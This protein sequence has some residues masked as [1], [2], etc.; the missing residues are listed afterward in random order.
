MFSLAVPGCCDFW[1]K[2]WR[3]LC[4]CA[5]FFSFS[6]FYW[7]FTYILHIICIT[8]LVLSHKTRRVTHIS[9]IRLTNCNCLPFNILVDS[10]IWFFEKKWRELCNCF[11]SPCRPC[12]LIWFIWSLLIWGRNGKTLKSFPLV[13]FSPSSVLISSYFWNYL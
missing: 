10:I 11:N 3:E 5:Y 13:I 7:V 9:K 2:T 1:L 6:I 12:C 8:L 4:N